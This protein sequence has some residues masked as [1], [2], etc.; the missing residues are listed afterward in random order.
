[1]MGAKKTRITC[2]WERNNYAVAALEGFDSAADFFD[3]AHKFMAQNHWTGL[4]N[5]AGIN[6]QVRSADSG[7]RYLQNNVPRI[8]YYGVIYIVTCHLP[9][10]MYNCCFHTIVVFKNDEIALR[11]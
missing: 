9:R 10:P 2:N 3:F 6:V 1:M 4:W 8:F 7:C 5:S 11:I